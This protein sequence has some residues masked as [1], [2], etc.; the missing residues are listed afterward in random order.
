MQKYLLFINKMQINSV[1]E[2]LMKYPIENIIPI[3][4]EENCI[5]F[6]S[7]FDEKMLNK[8]FKE[9]FYK[10][11]YYN[12]FALMDPNLDFEIIL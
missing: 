7:S 8:I 2:V 1:W 5:D 4:I 11:G 3:K 9:Y 10:I 6:K 12:T